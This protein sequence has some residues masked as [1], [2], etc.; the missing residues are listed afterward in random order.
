MG[1]VSRV[2][3]MTQPDFPGIN[4]QFVISKEEQKNLLLGKH[5]CITDQK[6]SSKWIIS[7]SEQGLN[8]QNVCKENLEIEAAELL[9]TNPIRQQEINTF[10]EKHPS[11]KEMY[12]EY[13]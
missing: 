1:I 9:D 4:P 12:Y 6:Y 3:V 11:W 10:F 2:W 13:K 8:E 5:I 7:L